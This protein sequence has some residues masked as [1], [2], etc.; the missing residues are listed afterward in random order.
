MKEIKVD[1][2]VENTN[3]VIE[4]VE[5][6][7]DC[8]GCSMK[9]KMQIDIAIDEIFSNIARY[10]YPNGIGKATIRMETTDSQQAVSI[11]FIDSGIPYNPLEK[12]DPDITLSTEERKIGGLG[13][14]MVK[15]NMDEMTYHYLDGKNILALKKKL[16]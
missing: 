14:Y 9:T 1:A 5:N 6:F 8:I 11:T 7:L 16:P 2:L 3:T 15:K 10:A 12:K 4:F 13:I